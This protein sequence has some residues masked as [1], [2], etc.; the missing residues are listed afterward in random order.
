MNIAFPRGYPPEEMNLL[1]ILDGVGRKLFLSVS[2]IFS[3]RSTS[4]DVFKVGSINAILPFAKREIIDILAK[5]EISIFQQ[6]NKTVLFWPRHFDMKWWKSRR[7]KRNLRA[8]FIKHNKIPTDYVT[9]YFNRLILRSDINSMID[10][11]LEPARF[12]ASDQKK[13]ETIYSVET[14]QESMFGIETRG[15]K[16]R[17]GIQLNL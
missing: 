12:I 17:A 16:G 2:Y 7:R 6:L 11:N 9:F 15:I 1:K 8:A 3:R 10:Q 5:Y 4:C 13:K 14:F